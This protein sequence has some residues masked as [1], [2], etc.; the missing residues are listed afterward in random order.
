MLDEELTQAIREVR[1]RVRSRY[2]EGSLGLEGVRA[3]DLTPV[4][5]ARDAAE[6]KVAAIGTVNPRPPGLKNNIAQFFK[7]TIA[8][9]LD[10][11][12]REQVEFNRASMA[13]VHATLEA[14]ADTGR[15]LAAL[16]AHHQQLQRDVRAAHEQ[17][18]EDMVRAYEQIRRDTGDL[19]R[20]A[21]ELKDIRRHW[22]EWRVGYEDRRDASEIHMLRTISELQGAF[23]HRVTQLEASFRELA[24][25]QHVQFAGAL[26]QNTL[27]VQKRLWRDLEIIRGEYEKLIHH[28]LKLIRQKASVAPIEAP[29]VGS[30]KPQVDIDWFRFAD[31]FRGSEERIREHQKMYLEKFAGAADLLDIGCGRGEF[32]EVAREAGIPARGIDQSEECVAICRSKGLLAERAELFAYLDSLADQS[33]GGVYCSQVVEHLPPERLP[34]LINLLAK[35]MNRGALLAIETPN[36]ECLAIFATHFYLDPTHTRPVPPPLSRFYMEEAG[37]VN[38]EVVRLE[39][40]VESMPSLAELPAPVRDA[41]FGGL[42]YAIFGTKG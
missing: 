29:V 6:A 32:L 2:P 3:P 22:A 36:P 31:V 12:V 35:K 33:L 1:E 37:F 7:R 28:E 11:H 17:L 34:D 41:F 42:D 25:Q 8:R 20:E 9:A 21:Q 10:W 4:V 5:Q 14:L 19:F 40:A 39:P 24:R 16:A 18:R 23:S 30:P 27:D 15:T 26:E 13:C 38:I